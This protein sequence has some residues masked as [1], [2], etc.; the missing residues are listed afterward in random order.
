MSH[1]SMKNPSLTDENRETTVRVFSR[2]TDTTYQLSH[3]RERPLPF[4]TDVIHG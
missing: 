3:I 2:F 1:E 4:D